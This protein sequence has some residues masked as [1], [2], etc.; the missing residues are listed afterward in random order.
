M[1]FS[2]V[3]WW[4]QAVVR[5]TYQVVRYEQ[6][7]SRHRS[8]YGAMVSRCTATSHY[9]VEDSS[10]GSHIARTWTGDIGGA[11]THRS[12]GAESYFVI[13]STFSH[14][15]PHQHRS[16]PLISDE[17]HYDQRRSQAS[18]LWDTSTLTSTSSRTARTFPSMNSA[19]GERRCPARENEYA[20]IV[21]MLRNIDRV[22]VRPCEISARENL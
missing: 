19:G 22:P 21:W 13:G 9:H 14:L 2:G 18:G 8:G 16:T 10:A 20:T 11:V 7:P 15:A 4:R 12:A 17:P 6:R 1:D 5:S 3:W